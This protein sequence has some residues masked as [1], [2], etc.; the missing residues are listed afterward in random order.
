MSILFIAMAFHYAACRCDWCE[1]TITC[2]VIIMSAE[3]QSIGLSYELIFSCLSLYSWLFAILSYFNIIEKQPIV[4][5]PPT[6]VVYERRFGTGDHYLLLSILIS[7]VCFIFCGWLT[8]IC[9]IPAI[10][11]AI[12]VSIDIRIMLSRDP[13]P[14][15]DI[16]VDGE[17]R[18]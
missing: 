14:S 18:V 3:G 8:L 11:F 15:N 10:F 2:T 5:T 16:W 4:V 6:F 12:S 7:I 13:T 17:G 1:I 9:T